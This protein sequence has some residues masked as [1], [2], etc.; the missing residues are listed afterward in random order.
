MAAIDDLKR[1]GA[2]IVDPA[3]VEL[4]DVRRPQGGGQCGGFK[5]DINRYLAAQGDRVP[6][7]TLEEI[8]RSRRFH[9]SIEARLRSAQEGTENGPDTPACKA[10][11]DYREQFRAR[12]DQDDGRQQARRVRLSDVE[13]PAA[14]DRRPEHAA[15]R[16]QPG[17]L[18]DDRI[19]GDQ[20]ADGLHA[21]D[22][23]GRA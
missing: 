22:A 18:A 7:H 6:V 10:E 1:A 15:R 16:Q 23:A 4:A 12:G 9:P 2:I 17:V 3:R 20:R 19:A 14:P 21:R 11:A 5:Y 13:Q 8:I